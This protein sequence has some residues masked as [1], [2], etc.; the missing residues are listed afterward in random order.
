MATGSAG[1]VVMGALATAPTCGAV[2][3]YARGDESSDPTTDT[4]ANL[5][6]A[7]QE[8]IGHCPNFYP[9]RPPGGAV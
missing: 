9:R 3:E 2:E 4:A 6:V 7:L 5:F 8:I 1:A